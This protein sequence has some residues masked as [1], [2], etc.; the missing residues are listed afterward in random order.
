[1]SALAQDRIE[2]A[3][4]G[5]A[6][7]SG[8]VDADHPWLGLDSFSEETRQYFHGREEEV[9]ELARRVQRKTLAILFGQS[10]LGKTSILRA[11]IVPRLRKEGF[12]PVYVR[13]DYSRESPAPSQQIKQA[14]FK[15]TEALGKW[16]KA[17]SAVPGESLWEFLHHRDDFLKDERGQTLTPLV[18]FDQFEEIFTLGQMDDFGRKRA[19]EFIQDLADLVENRPPRSIEVMMENE[20]SIVER[21]DFD[22]ADYRILI[23]L[24]EDYLAHLEGLKAQMPSITQNRMRLARMTGHQALAAVTKPGGKL[25]SEEVA[26]SIVRFVAGGAELR[27]AEV[28][29][30]LL[31]L[32]CREL[33]NARITQGRSEISADLLAG[34]RDTILHEFYERAL[35][36]Q[37]PGV[38]QFIEDEMLTE[39]GFRESLAEERVQKG[40]AAANALPS[41]LPLLVNRRLLRI[42]ERLD[43]RRVEITHDVLCAVVKASRDARREREAREEAER[44]LAAQRAREEATKRSLV[45]TRQV[46][47]GAAVLAI[48]AVV[49]AV[50]G[51]YNMTRAKEA[52]AQANATRGEAEK[53]V[54][55]LLDDFYLELQPVG[56]LDVVAALSKRALDYYAGLPPAMRTPETERNRALAQVRYGAALALLR[57]FPESDKALTDAIDTLQKLRGNGDRSEAAAIGLGLGY[58]ARARLM[59]T[60]GRADEQMKAAQAGVEVLQPLMAQASPSTSVR[61]A[62]G[63]AATRYGFAKMR[64]QQEV[65]GAK[66]LEAARDAYRGIDGLKLDDLNAAAAYAEA[67]AWLAEALL[68]QKKHDAARPIAEEAIQLT[69]QVL[70]RRPAHMAALRSR[71]LLL[72]EMASIELNDLHVR[73][74]LAYLR[75]EEKDYAA[76]ISL[77]PGNSLSQRNRV[78]TLGNIGQAQ[79]SLG[80]LSDALATYRLGTKITREHSLWDDIWDSPMEVEVL[81]ADMGIPPRTQEFNANHALYEAAA[82]AGATDFYRNGMLYIKMREREVA[83]I[84]GEFAVALASGRADA[85]KAEAMKSEGGEET[86]YINSMRA[87]IH[88]QIAWASYNLKDYATAESEARRSIDHLA[89]PLPFGDTGDKV[90]RSESRIFLAATI[91]RQGR[92]AEAKAMI[93]PELKFQRELVTRGSD[94]VRQHV[95]VAEALLAAAYASSPGEAKPYLKEAAGILDKLPPEAKKR[96]TVSQLRGWI[97]DETKRS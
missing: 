94:D 8:L 91:A 78:V 57:K 21:F 64:G 88:R 45:R 82:R 18:I 12:C 74:A 25:V 58:A 92:Q 61:R 76:F 81:E 63:D 43:T 59:I 69:T 28:E 35:T 20:D 97:T 93:E 56:R 96:K 30:S 62:Y 46:A 90:V 83:L 79:E 38:R 29:P 53:L 49:G 95:L 80:Q 10:G 54:G 42:E 23:A 26:E 55:Y 86:R 3:P 36:D 27:N 7:A 68:F 50:F 32:V 44:Q 31:S 1:M 41:A 77:D 47:I 39:S 65:E 66:L 51:W 48:L 5:S 89:G 16:T 34:S 17:G 84:N 40:F 9:G 33:N 75:Q 11:G 13:I 4:S 37:P 22:R 6:A 67:S 2:E 14:I 19:E 85:P 24:R 52:E 72:G 73:K 71:A 15:A 87:N 60:Q 70:D